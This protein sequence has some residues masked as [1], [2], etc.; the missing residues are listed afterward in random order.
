MSTT[1]TRSTTG[2]AVTVGGWL[3]THPVPRAPVPPVRHDASAGTDAGWSVTVALVAGAVDETHPDL[4]GATVRTCLP[5]SAAAH[6]PDP[7][8]TSHAALLVGT[9]H[10]RVQGVVPAAHLLVAPVLADHRPGDE[11]VDQAVRR[12]LAEGADVVVLPFG[13]RRLGRRLAVTLRRAVA[14]GVA[15]L[16][17][18]GDDDPD[19][20]AFPAAVSGVL[21]VAAHDGDALLPGSSRL[22]DL[23]APGRA[24]PGAVP[25]VD[26]AGSTVAC[27]LAAGAHAA[28]LARLRLDVTTHLRTTDPWPH[29]RRAAAPSAEAGDE[30][31]ERYGLL[32]VL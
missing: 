32:Q 5:S 18:A 29:P 1:G 19:G 25:G 14:S 22:A 26:L 13:R 7:V 4:V 8:S 21:A 10:A 12:T 28:H 2:A 6:D 30:A 16:A 31:R 15:V 23:C 24:V 20:L 27:V 11:A 9:G 3:A 17:A